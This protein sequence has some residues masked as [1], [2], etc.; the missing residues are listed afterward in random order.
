[1]SNWVLLR[2]LTREHEHW[3]QFP[4]ELAQAMPGAR[5][6]MP[7]LPGAGVLW[8]ERS[9]CQVEAIVR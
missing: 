6:V 1:M 2:G 3:G 4:A 5:V 8:R 7:D 9:P